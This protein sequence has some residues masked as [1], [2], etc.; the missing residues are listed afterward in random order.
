MRIANWDK[1]QSKRK[2]R[3]T[4]PWIKLH[5][6]ALMSPTWHQMVDKERGQFMALLLLADQDGFIT[7]DDPLVLQRMGGMTEPPDLQRF[8]DLG[9]LAG[10]TLATTC[11]PN[12]TPEKEIE[13]EKE[14]EVEKEKTLKSLMRNRN[15]YAEEFERFWKIYPRRIGKAVAYKAWQKARKRAPLDA[16]N[17]G[18]T[19][20]AFAVECGADPQYIP[21]PQ[22]WLNRDG[23]LDEDDTSPA[24]KQERTYDIAKHIDLEDPLGRRRKDAGNGFDAELPRYG[25]DGG[26]EPRRLI[27]AAMV[28]PEGE[29]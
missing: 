17:R 25:E 28:D 5:R 8:T 2:D 6:C 20:V 29:A 10:V 26:Q 16:I 13:I 24:A 4:T 14:V 22:T 9:L 23:W 12:V 1:F 11:Q 19:K 3:A 7:I 15:D 21:H 27:S 18:A